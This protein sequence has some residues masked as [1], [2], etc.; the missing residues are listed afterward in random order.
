MQIT[1]IDQPEP[2][3]VCDWCDRVHVEDSYCCRCGHF[4]TGDAP[5][6]CR[7]TSVA[8]GDYRCCIN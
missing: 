7:P 3:V 6:D 1:I 5:D 2:E 8:C 4:H